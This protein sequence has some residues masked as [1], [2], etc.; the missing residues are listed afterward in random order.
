MDLRNR[1]KERK[2]EGKTEKQK[3]SE[4]L[5]ACVVKTQKVTR[6]LVRVLLVQT[7]AEKVI[8]QGT[9]SRLKIHRPQNGILEADWSAKV[10]NGL[11]RKQFASKVFGK[12]TFVRS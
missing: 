3:K 10:F 9:I 1:E 5:K 12:N 7:G 2:I 8:S 4:W 6:S 11:I